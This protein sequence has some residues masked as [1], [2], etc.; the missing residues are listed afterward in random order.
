M[1][2]KRKSVQKTRELVNNKLA[3]ENLQ[4]FPHYYPSFCR[5]VRYQMGRIFGG[6][7]SLGHNQGYFQNYRIECR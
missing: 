4:H 2:N 3:S 1:E 6:Y 7:G 5:T